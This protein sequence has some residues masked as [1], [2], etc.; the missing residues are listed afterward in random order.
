MLHIQIKFIPNSL[1]SFYICFLHFHSTSL[2]DTQPKIVCSSKFVKYIIYAFSMLTSISN[3]TLPIAAAI[4]EKRTP[5][6]P[7]NHTAFT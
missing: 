7:Y 1:M 2:Y 3:L 4:S 6:T 5:I